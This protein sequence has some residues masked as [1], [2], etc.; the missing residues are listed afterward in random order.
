MGFSDGAVVKLLHKIVGDQS[1]PQAE[2]FPSFGGLQKHDFPTPLVFVF[3]GESWP[4]SLQSCSLQEMGSCSFSMAPDDS[5]TSLQLESPSIIDEEGSASGDCGSRGA[6][7]TRFQLVGTVFVIERYQLFSTKDSA[8]KSFSEECNEVTRSTVI[9]RVTIDA[10]RSLGDQK[11]VARPVVLSE[12][13]GLHHAFFNTLKPVVRL[14]MSICD[15]ASDSSATFGSSPSDAESGQGLSGSQS[16]GDSNSD[17]TNGLSYGNCAAE[18]TPLH[19]NPVDSHPA[20]GTVHGDAVDKA[21]EPSTFPSTSLPTGFDLRRAT[22]YSMLDQEAY[23]NIEVYRGWNNLTDEWSD[24]SRPAV[25]NLIDVIVTCLKCSRAAAHAAISYLDAYVAGVDNLPRGRTFFSGIVHACAVLGCKQVDHFFSPTKQFMEYLRSSC[26]ITGKDF[27]RF[28]LEVLVKLDFRLQQLTSLEI[29]ETLLHLCGGAAIEEALEARC[30]RRELARWDKAAAWDAESTTKVDCEGTLRGL[31]QWLKLC[32]CARLL[33]DVVVRETRSTMLRPVVLGVAIVVA[34]AR[35][36]AYRLPQPL[37]ELVPTRFASAAWADEGP[38]L[39]E[40]SFQLLVTFAERARLRDD[41][42][43][44]CG[45]G[46]ELITGLEFVEEC[47]RFCDGGTLDEVLRQ[48]YR[49]T[50]KS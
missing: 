21:C 4:T 35:W 36:V 23:Q 39:D 16:S 9:V 45:I 41:D 34:A 37:L 32:D 6:L 43:A 24:V 50:L 13:E 44:H 18:P 17:W 1:V 5:L 48:R 8:S 29:V 7:M 49:H 22:I 28:E 27:V 20:P 25:V 40:M 11:V 10:S 3:S 12:D 15:E 30:R 33:N 26:R 47:L 31:G 14:N 2:Q 19:P 46:E 42:Q 38:V